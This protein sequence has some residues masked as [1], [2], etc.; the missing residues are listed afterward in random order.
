MA[1]KYKKEGSNFIR[2]DGWVVSPDGMKRLKDGGYKGHRLAEE[3]ITKQIGKRHR[4]CRPLDRDA[5]DILKSV[6]GVVGRAVFVSN[7]IV[8]EAERTERE[9]S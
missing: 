9:E 2:S 3:S 6:K 7:A 4:V 8:K 1:S 5:A